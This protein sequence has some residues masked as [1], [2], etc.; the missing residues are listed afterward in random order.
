MPSPSGRDEHGRAR[1]GEP[2]RHEAEHRERALVA[3]VRV[4]DDDHERLVRARALQPGEHLQPQPQR[5]DALRPSRRREDE[6]QHVLGAGRDGQQVD[7]H[8]ERQLAVALLAGHRQHL[9]ALGRTRPGRDGQYRGLARARDP[10]DDGGA[11]AGVEQATQSG[12]GGVTT[13]QA[14]ELPCPEAAPVLTHNGRLGLHKDRSGSVLIKRLVCA[15]RR[16]SGSWSRRGARAGRGGTTRCPRD[17]RPS[18]APRCPRA[19]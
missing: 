19:R 9:A 18:P 15:P 4:V 6:L 11:G 10:G 12:K 13:H 5:V 17:R 14:V 8:P 3:P 16:T 1:P 2:V 7:E